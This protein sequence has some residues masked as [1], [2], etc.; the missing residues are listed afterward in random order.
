ARGRLF[1][2]RAGAPCSPA[3]RDGERRLVR[4]APA[5]A[6]ARSS[7]RPQPPGPHAPRAPRA[8][9][10][11]DARMRGRTDVCSVLRIAYCVLALRNRQY[12]GRQGCFFLCETL[13][14]T[15]AIPCVV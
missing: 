1:A 9:G 2:L 4:E 6:H 15:S 14:Q 7:A 13:P 12:A 11:A 3:R 5:A 8:P 10:G